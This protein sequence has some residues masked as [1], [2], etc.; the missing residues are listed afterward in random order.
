MQIYTAKQLSTDERCAPVSEELQVLLRTGVSGT[1][2]LS[3]V[4]QTQ[5]RTW[6]G[7]NHALH[8]GLCKNTVQLPG[9]GL[10]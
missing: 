9:L 1:Q 3:A 8:R 7:T 5:G 10:G 2:A 6:A 4:L